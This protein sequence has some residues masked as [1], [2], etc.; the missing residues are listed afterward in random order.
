VALGSRWEGLTGYDYIPFS[1]KKE[2]QFV[3]LRYHDFLW[4]T[5]Y[6]FMAFREINDTLS[7]STLEHEFKYTAEM[8]DEADSDDLFVND[9]CRVVLRQEYNTPVDVSEKTYMNECVLWHITVRGQIINIPRILS[10]QCIL[11]PKQIGDNIVFKAVDRGCEK[12]FYTVVPLSGD[13][14]YVKK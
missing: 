14:Y 9:D 1:D 13:V 2:N 10:Y 8:K 12:G 6:L 7:F 3:S 5:S 4:D 11:S